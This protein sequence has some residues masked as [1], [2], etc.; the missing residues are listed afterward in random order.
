[1]NR[2][3]YFDAHRPFIGFERADIPGHA[4]TNSH[5]SSPCFYKV[6]RNIHQ[7]I[8]SGFIPDHRNC[9]AA[10]CTSNHKTQR[11]IVEIASWQ[12]LISFLSFESHNFNFSSFRK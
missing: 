6:R 7:N 10:H 4:Y 3:L 8:K 1:M 11:I 5:V 12:I 9:F 2:V